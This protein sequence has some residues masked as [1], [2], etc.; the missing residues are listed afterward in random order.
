MAGGRAADVHEPRR[1]D[2]AASD[3][4]PGGCRERSAVRTHSQRQAERRHVAGGR[5]EAELRQWPLPDGL[6][7]AVADSPVL[8][9]S[10]VS[11]RLARR[12]Q[13]DRAQLCAAVLE[14]DRR[15]HPGIPLRVL[16][17]T[18]LGCGGQQRDPTA[19]FSGPGVHRRPV[20]GSRIAPDA[21]GAEGHRRKLPDQVVLR[22]CRPPAGG[23]QS[24]RSQLC[25]RLD[26]RVAGRLREGRRH[27]RA[28]VRC[29]RFDHAAVRNSVRCR[30]R[31]QRQHL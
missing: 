9:L 18:I 22:R 17:T 2:G 29:R 1:Q 16:A 19:D 20:P 3:R 10:S 26:A 28:G 15:W 23:E 27:T 14:A 30:R 25:R 11:F 8:E 5:R 12:G 24:R 21:A 4:R 6:P 13:R 7:Y 31:H